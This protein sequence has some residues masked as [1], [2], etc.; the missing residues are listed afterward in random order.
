MVEVGSEAIKLTGL[1][2]LNIMCT[3]GEKMK[4]DKDKSTDV[5]LV[6]ANISPMFDLI[7]DQLDCLAALLSACNEPI[8]DDKDLDKRMALIDELY[9]HAD[10]EEHAAAKFAEIIAARIHEYESETV[11]IPAVTQAEALSY[12]MKEKGVRQRELSDIAAQ[13]IISEILNEKRKMT[14]KH[15]KQFSEYF[16]V[17]VEYFLCES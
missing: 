3:V 11:L 15:V 7:S 14:V 16:N 5:D 12:L 2:N 6:M 9:S 10:S 17:P 1:T 13:S 8:K 4:R